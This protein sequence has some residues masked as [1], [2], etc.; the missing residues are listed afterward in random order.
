MQVDLLARVGLL[1]YLKLLADFIRTAGS[2]T[3]KGRDA[4]TVSPGEMDCIYSKPDSTPSLGHETEEARSYSDR[5]SDDNRSQTVSPTDVSTCLTPVSG[6]TSIEADQVRIF[7]PWNDLS[8]WLKGPPPKPDRVSDLDLLHHYIGHTS[9]TLS[10][11]S[12]DSQKQEGWEVTIPRL[13]FEYEGRLACSSGSIG[14][15][16][17]L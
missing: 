5:E 4:R 12:N 9:K 3:N 10:A 15:A 1:F 2:A 11:S 6:V 16:P 17:L 8:Q 13:V 14:A 7:D